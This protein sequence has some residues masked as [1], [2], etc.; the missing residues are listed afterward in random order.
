MG[1]EKIEELQARIDKMP[2][3]CK[4]LFR[5]DG[6]RVKSGLWCLSQKPT[7]LRLKPATGIL[8]M[9]IPIITSEHYNFETG[10]RFGRALTDSQTV[11][12]RAEGG[13]AGSGV[14]GGFV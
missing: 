3:R 8:E 6:V 4:Q 11:K 9:D 2:E 10:A 1:Q 12:L 7:A 14:A 13:W 5:S